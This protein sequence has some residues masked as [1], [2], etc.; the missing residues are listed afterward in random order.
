VNRFLYWTSGATLM[1]AVIMGL[2]SLLRYT[3]DNLTLV[4]FALPLVTVATIMV[5]IFVLVAIFDAI[6]MLLVFFTK[7]IGRNSE[8]LRRITRR[9]LMGMDDPPDWFFMMLLISATTIAI[10]FLATA[11]VAALASPGLLADV[12]VS[13]VFWIL[14]SQI[15]KRAAP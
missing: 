1:L 11:D 15:E 12:C 9:F 7:T 8:S 3:I 4:I 2:L 10:R 13:S 6:A 5:L 14:L